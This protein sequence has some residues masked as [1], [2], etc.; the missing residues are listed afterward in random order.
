MTLNELRAARQSDIYCIAGFD[1]GAVR[2]PVCH[3]YLQYRSWSGRAYCGSCHRAWRPLD[4]LMLLHGL[5]LEEAVQVVLEPLTPLPNR[6]QG[7]GKGKG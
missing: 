7:H 4:Y 6:T 1:L 5:T 3:E 2:C